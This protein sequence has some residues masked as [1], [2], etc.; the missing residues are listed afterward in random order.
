[1]SRGRPSR[2]GA[3]IFGLILLWQ[4]WR[5]LLTPHGL[6]STW[7]TSGGLSSVSTGGAGVVQELV[8]GADGFDGLWVRVARP[9]ADVTAPR[10]A[11]LLVTLARMDDGRPVPLERRLVEH[12]S[13][14]GGAWHVPFEEVRHSRG[15]TFR[16]GL[17][18]VSA[19]SSTPVALL[20]RPDRSDTAGRFEVD[21]VE[22][23]GALVFETTSG[24]ATLP[25]WKDEV[26]RP[27][28]A[29]LRSWPFV[30]ALWLLGNLLLAYVCLRVATRGDPP[31]EALPTRGDGRVPA[32]AAVLVTTLIVG[33]G[34]VI[35]LWP[36]PSRRMLLLADHLADARIETPMPLHDAIDVQ[37]LTIE[38]GREVRSIVA[39]P[40]ARITWT[41][42]VPAGAQLVG[43]AAMRADVW[44]KEGDGANLSVRIVDAAGVA[45][46]V[47]RFTL[48]PWQI[49]AH[50]TYHPFRVPLDPWAGQEVAIVFET[51]PER[52]GNA[53]NDVPIWVEPRV[54]Y[55]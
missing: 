21:G 26:L 5:L 55:R 12:S 8:M 30:I 15:V 40:P 34:I 33:A 17:Q 1:M 31:A 47:A 27:W 19:S 44:F 37:L 24:R 28:P 11:K 38:R 54:E 41:L 49:A 9:A 53:V 10:D 3:S 45:R 23:W 43:H 2:V 50:R 39:L 16:V 7:T 22:Q 36:M 29:W 48:F 4:V 51:D 32:R 52:W 13:M 6:A 14:Q 35:A 46:E 42:Q 25:Y 20:S 18:H